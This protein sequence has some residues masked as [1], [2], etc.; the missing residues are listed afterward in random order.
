MFGARGA[1]PAAGPGPV[2]PAAG[3]LKLGS[4]WGRFLSRFRGVGACAERPCGPGAAG[5]TTGTDP[6]PLPHRPPRGGTDLGLPP[7]ARPRL[8]QLLPPSDPGALA[9][10]LC[11]APCSQPGERRRGAGSRPGAGARS[12]GGRVGLGAGSGSICRSRGRR[13]GGLGSPV[14]LAAA[15]RRLDSDPGRAEGVRPPPPGITH[16]GNGVNQRGVAVGGGSVSLR[17]AS[18][19]LLQ[20]LW[21]QRDT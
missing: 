6:T 9:R 12:A 3:G 1:G 17:V 21:P 4:G 20:A 8:R 16:F 5:A 14:A 13:S 2:S 18:F 10:S 7:L 15:R 11:P 19:T